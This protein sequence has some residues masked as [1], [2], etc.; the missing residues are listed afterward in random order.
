MVEKVW[1]KAMEGDMQAFKE[2]TDRIDGKAVQPIAGD[3]DSPLRV[4]LRIASILKHISG[5]TSD[6]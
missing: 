6:L 4:E 3:D 2:I 1:E 5:N